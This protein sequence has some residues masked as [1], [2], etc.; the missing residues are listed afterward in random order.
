MTSGGGAILPTELS[1]ISRGDARA[2]VRLSCQV[3]VK[4]DLAIELPPE[5]FSVREWRCRV[6]SNHNVS[7]FI[8]ELVLELP[9]GE[10]VPFRAGGYIQIE[11][12]PA[13]VEY[14]DFDIDE[15][16]RADWDKFN[17]VKISIS[18]RITDLQALPL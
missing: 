5:V 11:A 4:Q 1:H 16:Y 18:C 7:T 3:K 9:E 8:K 14:A 6:R 12:P 17:R 15:E 13:T 2:G 10:S